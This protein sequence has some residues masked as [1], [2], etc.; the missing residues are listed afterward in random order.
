MT[1]R[2]RIVTPCVEWTG[3]LDRDGY[4]RLGPKSAHRMA[5]EA[6]Y[7]PIPGGLVIDHL[8]RNTRCVNPEHLEAVAQSLNVLRGESFA[9]VNARK[10]TCAHGHPFDAE[11]TLFRYRNGRPRRVCRAC[12]RRSCAEY[13]RRRRAQ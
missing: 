6:A 4:G 7:G 2:T 8:C 3:R 12:G 11:N 10:T 5:Y 1:E 9:S 13:Y